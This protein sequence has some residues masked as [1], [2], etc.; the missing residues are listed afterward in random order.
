LAIIFFTLIA[1]FNSI[2]KTLI[3][4]SE[5]VLSIIGVMLGLAIFN[6]PVTIVMTGI[7]IVA[8]GG[9]VVRN[10]ILIVE[11]AD[12]L[13]EAGIK[14]RE[15]IAQ[16]ATTRLT[17]VML[18]ALSTI[19][20]LVPLAVGMNIN[21]GTLLSSWNPHIFFGGDMVAF[22]GALAWTIVFG[23][24]MATFLTLIFI[25]AMYLIHYA[26]K[27]KIRRWRELRASRRADIALQR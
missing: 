27:L 10:G 25:P 14:T 21:F 16:A 26:M 9:I 2:G 13:K 15:A 1:Q 22:W 12:Q 11:F 18:T 20:G 6:M 4:L 8:L 24:V 23:L 3:I 17:P 7:G 5:V 19:F